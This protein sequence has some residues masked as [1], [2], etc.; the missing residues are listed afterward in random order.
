MPIKRDLLEFVSEIV[1]LEIRHRPEGDYY[2]GCCPLHDDNTPSFVVYPNNDSQKSQCLCF[3]CHPEAMDI[4]DFV[5]ELYGVSYTDAV[6]I[7]CEDE[8]IIDQSNKYFTKLMNF[9]TQE[10]FLKYS[11]RIKHLYQK[12]S[13]HKAHAIS[14]LLDSYAKKQDYLMITKLCKIYKI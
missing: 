14:F 10:D 12:F 2:I 9:E 6:Q 7:A 4:I 11:G 1:D 8:N 5:K 3:S 13:F